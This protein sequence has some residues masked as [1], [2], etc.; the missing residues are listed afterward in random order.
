MSQPLWLEIVEVAALTIAGAV[1]VFY[2]I[3]TPI[4]SSTGAFN[5]GFSCTFS[6]YEYGLINNVLNPAS[7]LASDFLGTPV[8]SVLPASDVQSSCLQSSN[9]NVNTVNDLGTQLYSKA[10]SCFGLLSGNDQTIGQKV[11]KSSSE[12]FVFSCYNGKILT[13]NKN[14]NISNFSALINYIDENYYNPSDPLQIAIITNGSEDTSEFPLLSQNVTNGSYYSI[15][16]FGFPGGSLPGDCYSDFQDRCNYVT[17]F[18]QPSLPGGCTYP[19]N[20][21]TKVVNSLSSSFQLP[22]N[23]NPPLHVCS[24]NYTVS[25]CGHLIN[26]MVLSQDRVFVCITTP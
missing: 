6:F 5:F 12:N 9:I 8:M 2:A 3:L 14:G 11:L 21:N 22:L 7:A 13:T 18:D 10:S 23:S 15:A 19:L 26:A 16:M 20:N 1:L 4:F 25:F 24:G 17:S